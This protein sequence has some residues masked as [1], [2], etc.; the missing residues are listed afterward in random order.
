MK[1]LYVEL[2][3]PELGLGIV[4]LW[5]WIR[6]FPGRRAR[7]EQ[8]V[9]AH[10]FGNFPTP[11]KLAA[12]PMNGT[13]I[14]NFAGFDGARSDIPPSAPP[15][16]RSYFWVSECV[17]QFRRHPSIAGSPSRQHENQFI[18]PQR[19][20]KPCS[21]ILPFLLCWLR[22]WHCRQPRVSKTR[23]LPESPPPILIASDVFGVLMSTVGL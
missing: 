13:K 2:S 21:S 7:G 11:L 3:N 23:P 19:P 17:G 20:Q 10:F 5:S 15:P 4:N 14:D 22:P 16:N 1:F 9:G 8:A 12:P 18:L 6:K